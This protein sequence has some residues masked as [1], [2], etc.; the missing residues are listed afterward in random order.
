MPGV[1]KVWLKVPPEFMVPLLNEPLAAVTVCGAPSLLVQITV[2]P[3]AIVMLLGWKEKPEMATLTLAGVLGAGV[4]AGLSGGGWV[5]MG[6]VSS[7]G[8]VVGSVVTGAD[9]GKFW[10]AD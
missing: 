2:S 5:G 4:G 3:T 6:E 7:D 10:E 1:E 8:L 9:V